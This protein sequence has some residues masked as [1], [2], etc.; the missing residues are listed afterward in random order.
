MKKL[1]RFGLEVE[2]LLLDE[3]G[4]VTNSAD[5]L[6]KHCSKKRTGYYVRQEA[7]KCM[8]EIGAAPKQTVR[9]TTKGFLRTLNDTLDAAEKL[10]L[11]LFPLSSY[12][13]KM[14]PKVRTKD[15]YVMQERLVGK[16]AWDNVL[17]KIT[18]FHFHYR[19]PKGTFDWEHSKLRHVLRST[20]ARALINQYNFLVAIDPAITTLMQSSPFYNG[21]YVY[22]DTRAALYRDLSLE[23][24]EVTGIYHDLPSLG[25]LPHYEHTITDINHHISARKKLVVKH[26]KKRDPALH[27][28]I[29]KANALRFYWGPLRINRA[30]TFEQRGMD[31]NLISNIVGVSALIKGCLTAIEDESLRIMPSEIGMRQPF[32]QEGI[33]VYM[34]PFTYIKNELQTAALK[35]GMESPAIKDY[36]KRFYRFAMD[37][38]DY[39]HDIALGSV[40]R[41]IDNGETVSDEMIKYVK[42]RGERV[43]GEIDQSVCA[44]LA[45]RYAEELRHEVP[46]LLR[47][48][49]ALDAEE[50]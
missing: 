3:A 24:P 31:M 10:D 21:H 35:E 50:S 7:S 36:C 23:K 22:K 14:V 15:W 38:L 17:G 9:R 2:F 5:I 39:P 45:L 26:L 18:G 12:P 47:H 28:R 33:K 49:I 34:P 19:L 4:Q 16:K 40:K 8:L 42:K 44:E 46:K 43:N 6:M 32:R 30:G 27:R 13:G 25:G 11:R 29:K 37:Y 48:Y 41:M 1:P 20:S